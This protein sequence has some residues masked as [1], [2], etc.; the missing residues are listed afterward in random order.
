[1]A[2]ECEAK[3]RLTDVD[4]VKKRL[5]SL[6]AMNEGTCLER[7]WLLDDENG[8]LRKMGIRLRIRSTGGSEGV[9]TIKMPLKGNEFKNR[10]EIEV[11]IESSD[12]ALRQFDALGYNVTWIYEKI[13]QTWTYQ[14]CILMIDNCPDMGWFMEIEGTPKKIKAVAKALALDPDGHIND[15]YRKLWKKYLSLRGRNIPYMLFPDSP[16]NE[17]VAT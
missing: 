1:M 7:N 8:S 14:D 12:V 9:L 6:G 11:K 17:R 15:S 10:E 16:E 5:K 4:R 13:R 2:R 3:F